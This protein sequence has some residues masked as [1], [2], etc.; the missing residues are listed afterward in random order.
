MVLAERPI[1][2]DQSIKCKDGILKTALKVRKVGCEGIHHQKHGL[3]NENLIQI[4]M[5][6][7]TSSCLDHITASVPYQGYDVSVKLIDSR[8]LSIFYV[9]NTISPAFELG[10][11]AYPAVTKKR[12]L[13]CFHTQMLEILVNFTDGKMSAIY[14]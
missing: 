11:L 4:H 9:Y 7:V 1:F 6:M 3:I 8:R 14:T 10:S 13:N 5:I 2:G 12:H